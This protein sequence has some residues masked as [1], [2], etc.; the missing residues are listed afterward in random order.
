MSDPASMPASSTRPIRI[1]AA[2]DSPMNLFLIESH[3]KGS[4]FRLETAAN[5][6]AAVEKFRTGE[7][8]LVLM[9]IQMPVM[10]G[11]TATR[12]IRAWEA[13]HG[14]APT[15]I[16]ALTAHGFA[17]QQGE[18]FAAGC[19]AHLVKPIRK[20]SLLEAIQA[21]AGRAFPIGDA[22]ARPKIVVNAAPGI[23]EAVP[24]FLEMTR[25][26]LHNL[27]EALQHADY[28]KI[29]FIGHDLKG[30]AGGYGFDEIGAIGKRL[31]E[32]AKQSD[33]DAARRHVAD[34]EDYLNRLEVVYR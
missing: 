12:M 19:N 28:S 20:A 24:L 22:G 13:Q 7:F 6:A 33:P 34:L 26:D 4:A 14:K 5:G 16:L 2:E 11:Y 29:R 18:S 32:A 27:A 3:L 9:D 15:P 10:D 17:E 23:E 1:L 21:F 25:A 31:E 8:D 30:S